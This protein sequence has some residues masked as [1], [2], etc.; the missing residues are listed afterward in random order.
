MNILAIFDYFREIDHF[1][2]DFLL[3]II[4]FVRF[5]AGIT[6]IYVYIDDNTA[7]L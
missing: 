5:S 6:P 4:C 1:S 2:H 3:E 7:Y